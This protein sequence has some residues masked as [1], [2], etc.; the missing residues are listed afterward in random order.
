M[1]DLA[2]TARR[3]SSRLSSA[4]FDSSF[5]EL[6]AARD[7]YDRAPRSPDDV[8]QLARASARL[9]DARSRMHATLH[10]RRTP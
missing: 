5:R 1:S 9:A 4:A 7:T 2:T 6:S 10:G 8:V 3:L